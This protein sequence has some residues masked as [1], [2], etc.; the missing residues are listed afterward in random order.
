MVTIILKWNYISSYMEKV[1]MEGVI[2]VET[3]NQLEDKLEIVEDYEFRKGLGFWL[4]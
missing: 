2:N 1:G 4:L 3:G